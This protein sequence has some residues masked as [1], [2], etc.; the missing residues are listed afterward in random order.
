MRQALRSRIMPPKV[1]Q[2]GLRAYTQRDLVLL[3]HKLLSRGFLDYK[4]D[5]ACPSKPSQ[6]RK[7]FSSLP[8]EIHNKIYTLIESECDVE[9]ITWTTP[10]TLAARFAQVSRRIRREYLPIYHQHRHIHLTLPRGARRVSSETRNWLS[11][12]GAS[13]LPLA[14]TV[15]IY[16]HRARFAAHFRGGGYEVETALFRKSA[17]VMG[18]SVPATMLKKA[19][20]EVIELG[21]EVREDGRPVMTMELLGQSI[22]IFARVGGKSSSW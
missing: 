5:Q 8:G 11:V 6:T 2:Q 7:T 13:R 10:L 21:V 1:R 16:S 18:H 3:D 17:L 15:S 12:F 22:D 4:A 9:V 19:M 20:E 14:E